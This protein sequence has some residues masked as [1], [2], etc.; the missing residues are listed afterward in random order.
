MHFKGLVPEVGLLSAA[1][2]QPG[3]LALDSASSGRVSRAAPCLC[4]RPA[5]VSTCGGGAREEG[6]GRPA[7]LVVPV[8]WGW[9]YPG[10]FWG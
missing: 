1:V 7:V 10:R 8:P 4:L 2:R 6:P 5:S 3:F 9:E